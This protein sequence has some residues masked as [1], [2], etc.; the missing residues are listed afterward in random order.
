[1]G[2]TSVS[3]KVAIAI[4][5]ALSSPS[6][7]VSEPLLLYVSVCSLRQPRTLHLLLDL[8]KFEKDEAMSIYKPA[9]KSD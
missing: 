9:T 6:V 2:L 5:L 4:R 7:V 1:M 8:G 3:M